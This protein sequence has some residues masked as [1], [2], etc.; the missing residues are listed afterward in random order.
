MN[1]V[2]R[3]TIAL[4]I[5]FFVNGAVLASWAPRI[6]QVKSE[7]VLT[8]GQLGWAL[9]GIA[10]GSVPALFGTARLLEHVSARTCCAVAAFVFAAAL[11]GIGVAPNGW[12]LGVVLAGLGAASGCLDV[13]MNTAAIRYQDAVGRRVLSRLHG[14]YSLGVL[15]GAASGALASYL[16][17]TVVEHFS[18]MSLGL[19]VLV[20]ASSVFLPTDAVDSEGPTGP[21]IGKVVNGSTENRWARWLAIP[22]SVGVIAVA[23]LL[24]EGMVTDWSALVVA[25]DFGGGATVGAVAVVVFSSAMF[26][27]RS[28]GDVVVDRLGSVVTVRCSAVVLTAAV[29]AGFV[30]QSGPWPVVVALGVA[31][32][33]LGPLFPL[34]ITDAAD[35]TSGGAAVATARVS[36]VGYSAYLGGPP[37]VGFLADHVGLLTAFVTI[38]CCCGAALLVASRS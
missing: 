15:V 10:A 35:R 32:L 31:G 8:D 29:A 12:W 5:V 28:F 3:S 30:A 13:A 2:R 16:G 19:V 34:A 24:A 6:P 26:L 18:T 36:A 38:A 7:L 14:G 20:V 4:W 21:M 27:S 25:R 22:V 23:A 37:V 17:V 11:P 1:S 33:V 9:L